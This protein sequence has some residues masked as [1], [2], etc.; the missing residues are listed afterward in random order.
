MWHIRTSYILYDNGWIIIYENTGTVVHTMHDL[1]S[2]IFEKKIFPQNYI[3]DF[4]ED[5]FDFLELVINLKLL[6]L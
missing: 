4:I 5:L 1:I 6:I 2:Y 3:V